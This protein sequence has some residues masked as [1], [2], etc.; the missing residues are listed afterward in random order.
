LNSLLRSLLSLIIITSLSACNENSDDPI[1][2]N[3]A[4]ITKPL[5]SFAKD[6]AFAG[7]IRPPLIGEDVISVTLP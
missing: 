4:D 7:F 5:T 6:E 3:A 2:A 1:R